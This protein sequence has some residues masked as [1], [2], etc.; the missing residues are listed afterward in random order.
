MIIPTVAFAAPAASG[1]AGAPN[2]N[3]PAWLAKNH[4]DQPDPPPPPASSSRLR[5]VLAAFMVLS[6]IGFAVWSK[7]KKKNLVA[8]NPTAYV[9]VSDSVKV[10]DKAHLVVAQIGD[11]TV[12]LGVTEHGVRRLMDIPVPKEV[13]AAVAHNSSAHMKVA[14]KAK[15]AEIEAKPIPTRISS[16]MQAA[17]NIKTRFQSLLARAKHPAAARLQLA[18]GANDDD[19]DDTVSSFDEEGNHWADKLDDELRTAQNEANE[20][21]SVQPGAVSAPMLRV[22]NDTHEKNSKRIRMRLSGSH[23]IDP[24]GLE[25]QV[26]GLL[27]ARARRT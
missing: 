1:P 18:A 24:L 27:T 14:A 25:E 19:S 3:T 5:G 16:T 13:A 10:G 12:V 23:A 11:R 7:A 6:L 2:S 8:K 17:T 20:L 15:P 26:S 9:K 21:E 4:D 22:A